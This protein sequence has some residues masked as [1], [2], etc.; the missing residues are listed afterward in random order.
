MWSEVWR[1]LGG[2]SVQSMPP[3][4]VDLLMRHPELVTPPRRLEPLHKFVAGVE[5]YDSGPRPFT[6][7]DRATVDKGKSPSYLRVASII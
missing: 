3:V 5:R 2:S 7:R 4:D 6:G 1:V